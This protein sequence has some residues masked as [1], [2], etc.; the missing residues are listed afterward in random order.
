MSSSKP[1]VT[2][3][4]STLVML[5][6]TTAPPTTTPTNGVKT[7]SPLRPDIASNCDAFYYVK[8]GDNCDTISKANG[9]STTQFLAWNPSAGSDCAGLRANAYACASIIGH[10]PTSA[11]PSTTTPGN[12]I[13]TPT[14]IQDGMVSNCDSFYIVKLEDTCDKISS[15]KGITSAQIISWNRTVAS[16]CGTLWVDTVSCSHIVSPKVN[17]ITDREIQYICISIMGHTPTTTTKA[18]ATS[19]RPTNG[20][21]TLTPYQEGITTSC[22]TFHYVGNGENC[23]TTSAKFKIS[24]ADFVKWN[25]AV[26]STC[27]GYG[28]T[29][30]VV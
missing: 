24:M 22:K 12:G 16:N 14:P 30:P 13:T 23:S 6:S 28:Q 11:A 25:P 9:I 3:P 5:P 29:Q 8:S 19:T 21:T 10:T 1:V 20:V 2:T 27:A 4:S 15:A 26:D 7:P 17:C 18:P